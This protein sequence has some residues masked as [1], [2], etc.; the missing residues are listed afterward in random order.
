MITVEE[1]YGKY[2]INWKKKQF[3]SFDILFIYWRGGG[4]GGGSY[5]IRHHIAVVN[6]A[7]IYI[8]VVFLHFNCNTT[9]SLTYKSSYNIKYL[10]EV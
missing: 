9:S 4:G 8:C 5:D 7:C 6:C 1:W 2:C 3:Y 10:S